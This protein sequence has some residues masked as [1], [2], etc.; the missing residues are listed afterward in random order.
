MAEEY[1]IFEQGVLPSGGKV[2]F[3]RKVNPEFKI[4]SMTTEEEMRRLSKSERPLKLI[5]DI[6]DDC[7]V[8]EKIGISS[9]DMCLGDY[10]YLLHKLRTATY[11][12]NYRLDSFCPF[13][14]ERVAKTINLD[15][16]EIL[17]FPEDINSMLSVTLPRSKKEVK[18]KIQ[19]PRDYD[20]IEIR[21]K[22]FQKK[23]PDSKT[24]QSLL[25]SICAMI[26]TI[27]G[28]RLDP[29]KLE[30]FIRNLP[31][32]DTNKITKAQEKL[33][34]AIGINTSIEYECE[35]CGN[36]FRSPFR[37]TPEFYGPED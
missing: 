11:G 25:F 30:T 15:E 12:P 32:A 18:L 27:D 21:K 4:R 37:I 5:C 7:I 1:T 33:I 9:Y 16:M 26:E 31:M 36:T 3:D 13:C 17:P 23:F 28:E 19:T 14:G 6:I 29:F 24:D 34:A 2:Y 10:Q 20:N 35:A 8:G 22:D